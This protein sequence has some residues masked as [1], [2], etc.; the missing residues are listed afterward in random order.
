MTTAAATTA[1][2][3]PQPVELLALPPMRAVLQLA[4]PTT[5]VML[6]GTAT[7]VLYTYYVSRL[8]AD[9]IAAV[10][11]VFPIALLATTA[12]TGGLGGGAASGV[13]R[14]LGAGQR[15]H[16]AAVAEHAIAIAVGAGLLLAV[17][18]GVG[19]PSVFAVMGGTSAVRDAATGFARVVFGGAVVT[20]LGAMLDSVLRGE[21][22]VRVPAIWS[23]VSLGLQIVLTPLC[24]FV[25]GWGLPGAAIAV[26][27]AQA[28]ALVPR[29]RFVLGDGSLVRPRPWPRRFHVAP[30]R[31]ILRVGVPASL[32]TIINYLGLILLTAVLARL[33]TAHLAAYGLCTRFDFLL[34]SFAYGFAAA[35]LTLV[36]LTTG[37]RRPDRAR[38]YVLRAGACIVA[39][40]TVPAVVLSWR[41]SLWIDLFSADPEI[42]AVGATYF[43]IVGPSYP[44]VAVSM[45][46]AFAFQG[47]GRAVVPLVWMAIRVTGVLAVAIG[48]TRWLGLGERA[49]FAAV[50]A[51]NTISAAVML[52]LFARTERRI[53]DAFRTG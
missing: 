32:S 35:V 7:N 42:H 3:R 41:P 30:L 26:I 52:G 36:G 16:A 37:A 19:G 34:M 1:R 40:L 46:L 29:A 17:L 50:A 33:G 9:A 22:N 44:F 43:R 10:S 38:I 12:M 47:L 5:L 21:G 31:E 2:A 45:V 13:A 14:A 51:G 49:V 6:L 11:L 39:L 28:I 23:S 18:I 8:G 53:R 25:L 27:V 20:F 15:A 4:L 48:A 24:M